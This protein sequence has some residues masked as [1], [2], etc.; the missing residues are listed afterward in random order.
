MHALPVNPLNAQAESVVIKALWDYDQ[1]LI[2]QNQVLM[3]QNQTLLQRIA[4]LE[5][6][7]EAQEEQ[8]REL[9]RRTNDLKTEALKGREVQ[10]FIMGDGRVDNERLDSHAKRLVMMNWRIHKLEEAQMPHAPAPEPAPV[11][12]LHEPEEEE[13]DEEPEEVP[14]EEPEEELEEVPDSD[15]DDDDDGDDL[16]DGDVHD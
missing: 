15:G 8:I 2:Q 12:A 10:G 9:Y 1:I 4:T 14:E 13:S 3:E 7:V 6:R 16:G 11:P 5:G